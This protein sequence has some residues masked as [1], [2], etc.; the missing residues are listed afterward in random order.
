MAKRYIQETQEGLREIT[1]T[2]VNALF[3]N[4]TKFSLERLRTEGVYPLLDKLPI[5]PEGQRA[6]RDGAPVKNAAGVQYLQNYVLEPAP[7]DEYPTLDRW[8]LYWMLEDIGEKAA[9]DAFIASLPWTLTED[10]YSDKSTFGRTDP[11]I[12]L[13]VSQVSLNP[14]Q[15]NAKWLEAAALG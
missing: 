2:E 3:P 6:V 4:T 14:P 8:Q 12:N 1:N 7:I 11:L 9:V 15:F 5:V 13:I 10:Q